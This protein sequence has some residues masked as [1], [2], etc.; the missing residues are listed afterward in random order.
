MSVLFDTGLS[1]CQ[2][3]CLSKSGYA[4]ILAHGQML[5]QTE[6]T[7]TLNCLCGTL[8]SL[9]KNIWYFCLLTNFL[10]ST[11]MKWIHVFFTLNWFSCK[12]N[13]SW[14]CLIILL[15]LCI[16]QTMEPFWQF[17]LLINILGSLSE[18]LYN[19]NKVKMIIKSNKYAW[20]IFL[21]HS[22]LFSLFLF[23]FL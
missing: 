9:T 21:L 3:A 15:E 16:L 5:K 12:Y 1:K 18:S 22:C 11:P 2:N 10:L 14:H 4:K 20:Y 8:V 6:K 17:Q 7:Y 13:R 19:K 23:H